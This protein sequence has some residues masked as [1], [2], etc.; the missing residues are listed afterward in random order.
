[1]LFFIKCF[2][3]LMYTKLT[4]VDLLQIF[5]NVL[6]ISIFQRPHPYIPLEVFT[7]E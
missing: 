5:T 4:M 3:V 7:K 6:A 2:N 1:M